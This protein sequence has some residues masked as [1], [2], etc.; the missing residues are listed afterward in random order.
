MSAWVAQVKMRILHV[1][2][3]CNSWLNWYYISPELIAFLRDQLLK[4]GSS[5][6][7]CWSKFILVKN[8]NKFR[9]GTGRWFKSLEYILFVC[10]PWVSFLAPKYSHQMS[11][12]P[13]INSK[14]KTSYWS[15]IPMKNLTSGHFLAYCQ[16]NEWISGNK[17]FSRQ[18]NQE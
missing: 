12:L 7:S 15:G 5:A 2:M 17:S 6:K 8:I 9:A 14:Q 11:S 13:Q 4:Y 10:M 1:L 18:V 16:F 3:M